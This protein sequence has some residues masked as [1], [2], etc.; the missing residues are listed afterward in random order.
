M[1]SSTSIL[2]LAQVIVFS[3][4]CNTFFKEQNI[5]SVDILY[6]Q[7]VQS[8]FFFLVH[9]FLMEIEKEKTRMKFYYVNIA[10]LK[11]SVTDSST[12]WWLFIQ[13]RHC[14]II[15]FSN[16]LYKSLQFGIS[17]C[18]A[19]FLWEIKAIVTPKEICFCHIY[20]T[21]I[22]LLNRDVL[23]LYSTKP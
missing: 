23:R 3:Y 17:K 18:K 5:F 1:S 6:S 8:R 10:I 22:L 15:I 7:E 9:V 2:I 4:I 16:M 21:L 13:V 11:G 20:C 14:L 12:L 19:A